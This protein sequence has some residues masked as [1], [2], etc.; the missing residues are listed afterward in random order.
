MEWKECF[1]FQCT[2]Q[3]HFSW[4]VR[5]LWCIGSHALWEHLSS[6]SM[7]NSYEE[8]VLVSKAVAC[9]SASRA[10]SCTASVDREWLRAQWAT[11]CSVKQCFLPST[12]LERDF[13]SRYRLACVFVCIAHVC[14]VVPVEARRRHGILWNRWYRG[15]SPVWVLRVQPRSSGRVVSVLKHWAISLAC[16]HS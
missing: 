13:S 3:K 6:H 12:T 11:L 15:C 2:P 4:G 10:F 9:Y 14:C 7:L 8:N 1:L 5:E 16:L